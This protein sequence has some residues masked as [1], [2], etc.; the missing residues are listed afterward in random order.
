MPSI[1]VHHDGPVTIVEINRPEKR[2]AVDR[3][4]AEELAKAFRYGNKIFRQIIRC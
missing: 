1:N 2:N 4:T 3:N